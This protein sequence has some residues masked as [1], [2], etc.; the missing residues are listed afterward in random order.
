MTTS[1][2]R[3]EPE[4]REEC[5]HIYFGDVRVGAIAIKAGAPSDVD[6]WGWVCGFHAGSYPGEQLIGSAP[7]FEQA[8]AALRRRTFSADRTE[9][10]YQ[11]WR[12]GRNWNAWRRAM[13]A[14]A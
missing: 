7:D 5:W 10:D 4:A 12:D 9:A 3:R 14:L 1:T 13:W 2:R 6:Q 11:A 8:R